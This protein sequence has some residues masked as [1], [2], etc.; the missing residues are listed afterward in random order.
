MKTLL[1]LLFF[2]SAF[3][4]LDEGYVIL[5]ACPPGCE[6]FSRN[7]VVECRE[8]HLKEIPVLKFAGHVKRL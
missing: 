4:F 8:A 1:L 2:L 6:C 3:F 5:D 7:T